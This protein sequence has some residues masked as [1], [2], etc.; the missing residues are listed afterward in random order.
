MFLA[1]LKNTKWSGLYFYMENY[2]QNL[3]SKLVFYES[4]YI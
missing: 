4:E 2:G 3:I 1:W